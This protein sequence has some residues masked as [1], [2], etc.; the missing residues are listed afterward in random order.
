[1]LVLSRKAD[2]SIVIGEGRQQCVVTVVEVRGNAVRIGISA[3][4]SVAIVRSEL[5]DGV[6]AGP[7]HAEAT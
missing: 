1:M 2:E 6:S 4:R 3:D 5:V 7:P